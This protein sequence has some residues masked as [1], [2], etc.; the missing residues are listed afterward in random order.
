MDIK[1]GSSSMHCGIEIEC[2]VLADH[3]SLRLQHRPVSCRNPEGS[4]D[5]GC[6]TECS[7]HFDHEFRRILE[8][9][10]QS[11]SKE[12]HNKHKQKKQR[13]GETT[14]PPTQQQPLPTK[15]K[16]KG[17]TV[18]QSKRKEEPRCQQKS[19]QTKH[20]SKASQ[21][22]N[23]QRAALRID[24]EISPLNQIPTPH[25]TLLREV[26]PK[27]IGFSCVIDNRPQRK[28]GQEVPN[29]I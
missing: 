5:D 19:H 6:D 15:R 21:R 13:A 1:E 10:R 24:S 29:I 4:A 27:G 25:R 18:G 7:V 26:I 16:N 9:Q 23:P 3:E 11:V 12:A 20:R 22:Q 28:I 14:P 17:H 8:L 2:S